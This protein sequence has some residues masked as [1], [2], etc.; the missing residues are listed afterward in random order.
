MQAKWPTY[1]LGY[2]LIRVSRLRF[3]ATHPE[4]CVKTHE[5]APSNW[6]RELCYWIKRQV[7]DSRDD[8]QLLGYANCVGIT[9]ASLSGASSAFVDL[10]SARGTS[11]SS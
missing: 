4:L 5:K 6:L 3:L 2:M 11:S 9:K 1:R 10:G 8:M 7:Y